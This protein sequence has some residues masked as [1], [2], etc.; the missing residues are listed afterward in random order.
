[1]ADDTNTTDHGGSAFPCEGGLDSGL[2]PD[3]GMSLR[4]WFAGQALAG[5]YASQ[6]FADH[7]RAYHDTGNQPAIQIGAAKTA[8][9]AADA[10]IA[11]RA[12]PLPQ[13]RS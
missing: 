13:E 8:Y 5:I 10:M 7:C 9:A 12:D 4:D 6:W 11:A 3:P 1:M 2:Y